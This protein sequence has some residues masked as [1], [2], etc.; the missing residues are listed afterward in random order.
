ML[1]RVRDLLSKLNAPRVATDT[2]PGQMY[3]RIRHP[4]LVFDKEEMAAV[5]PFPE[6]PPDAPAWG[7]VMEI[8]YPGSSGTLTAFGNG[9]TGLYNN[10]GQGIVGDQ[11]M[12]GHENSERIRRANENLIAAA[13]KAIPY[14][15]PRTTYELPAPWQAVLY[16]RTDSGNLAVDVRGEDFSNKGHPLFSLFAAINELLT[17]L[18][19]V[20]AA[21]RKNDVLTRM[22]WRNEAIANKPNDGE[23]YCLRAEV[24][25][26]LGEFDKALADFEKVLE[27]LPIA[28][29]YLGRGC[30]YL[31]MGD[32][33]SALVDFNRA[34]EMEPANA[35]AYSNRGAAY[36]KLEDMENALV[37][38]DRAIQCDP[39][40]G[41]AYA[42]RGFAYYKLGR[43]EDGVADFTRS[44][45]LR[46]DHPNTCSDRGLC[47][48]ALGDKEGART[49]F[50]RALELTPPPSVIQE[51]LSGLYALDH[52]GEAIP[53]WQSPSLWI[54][55]C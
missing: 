42:N 15:T 18:K 25:A 30:M 55:S 19:I 50:N 34:I 48:A 52:P 44:L 12:V 23:L 49:D 14:L 37:N 41:N 1:S 17:E 8:A 20:K 47:R 40:Y 24:Y 28:D 35:M 51:A 54:V 5:A 29:A 33:P 16:V 13:S 53:D 46:P 4:A 36:S 43:Y 21:Q 38:Y 9:Q 22:S 39:N 10:D 11:V 3:S 31:N 6:L 2:S 26:E 32:I 27:L 45:A 7:A